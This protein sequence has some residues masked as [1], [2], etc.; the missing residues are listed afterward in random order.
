MKKGDKVIILVGKD[1]KKSGTIT[2]V[3]IKKNM[4]IVSGL[5]LKKRHK[6]AKRSDQK[7]SIVEM[8][9]PIHISNVKI[10]K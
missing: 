2:K 6:R 8:E 9:S 4:V 3:L 7:G 1:K 10:E 5:N